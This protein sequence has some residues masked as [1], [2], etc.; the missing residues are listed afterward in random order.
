MKSG[1]VQGW[2]WLFI[3]N[4]FKEDPD[5]TKVTLLKLEEWTANAQTSFFK[6]FKRFICS[7][8]GDEREMR[9]TGS[10]FR[11]I[12]GCNH[13]RNYDANDVDRVRVVQQRT[14]GRR[15]KG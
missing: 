9:R 13:G 5:G 15:G 8:E 10:L 4:Y 6:R 7:R 11:S 1:R 2:S 14:A 3:V 12:H